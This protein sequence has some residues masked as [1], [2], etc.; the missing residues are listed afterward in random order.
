MPYLPQ[1][2]QPG[3]YPWIDEIHDGIHQSVKY[4]LAGVGTAGGFWYGIAHDSRIPLALWVGLGL[5]G[6]LVATALLK[7]VMAIL[8]TSA[9]VATATL[10][11]WFLLSNEAKLRGRQAA[12]AVQTAPASPTKWSPHGLLDDLRNGVQ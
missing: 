3:P 8:I 12:P 9:L 11:A 7:H 1:Q 6:G 10:G 5:V 2:Q 4:I